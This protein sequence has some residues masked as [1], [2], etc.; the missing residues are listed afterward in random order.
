MRYMQEFLVIDV[1]EKI[2]VYGAAEIPAGTV[3]VG[4]PEVRKLRVTGPVAVRP[5]RNE[6]TGAQWTAWIER[7]KAAGFET[8]VEPFWP[9]PLASVDSPSRPLAEAFDELLR[10]AR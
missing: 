7:L 10:L 9:E 2:G 8:E 6:L 4:R 5:P 3:V 1:D